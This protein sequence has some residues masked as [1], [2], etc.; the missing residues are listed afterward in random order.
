MSQYIL[1]G[2]FEKRV[3]AM[4]AVKRETLLDVLINEL[5]GNPMR[6]FKSFSRIRIVFNSRELIVYSE[7]Y[8]SKILE[9]F[10]GRVLRL[11]TESQQSQFVTN[12]VK[13]PVDLRILEAL[14]LRA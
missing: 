8:K 9:H 12:W 2:R 1:V 3:L 6:E 10:E 4:P 7:L 11:S 14:E 5:P 13:G